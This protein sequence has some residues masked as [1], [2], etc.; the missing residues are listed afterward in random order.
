MNTAVDDIRDATLAG[1]AE[2]LHLGRPQLRARD[3]EVFF[4]RLVPMPLL[5]ASTSASRRSMLADAGIEFEARAPECDEDAVKRGHD[6]DLESLVG[7]LAALKASSLA[8]DPGDWVIG[9]DSAVEVEGVRYSKPRDRDQ[10]AQ[11]LKAFSGRTMMLASAVALARDGAIDWC[12]AE[13]A[14]LDVRALSDSFIATYLD[15]E[16]PAV[17]YCVGVFRIEARGVQLFERI[18]GSHFT[19]LGMPLLPLLGALRE[20]GAIAA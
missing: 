20:R 1:P 10:A 11:H 18:E 3:R 12:H 17:S 8:V 13:T 14:R 6:G 4:H 2:S 15:A 9:S 7:K 16:W 5:L 19:V